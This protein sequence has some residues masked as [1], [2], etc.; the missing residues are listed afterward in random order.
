MMYRVAA[1]A[2]ISR[3]AMQTQKG[4]LSGIRVGVVN[5]RNHGIN[6]LFQEFEFKKAVSKDKFGMENFSTSIRRIIYL[7]INFEDNEK[8]FNE[9]QKNY[10]KD[11]NSF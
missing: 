8:N 3:H 5:T 7:L 10:P 9:K 4:N 2:S 11:K 1:K 6:Q